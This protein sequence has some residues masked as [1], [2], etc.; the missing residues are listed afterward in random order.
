MKKPA[1]KKGS[2]SEPIEKR[3]DWWIFAGHAQMHVWVNGGPIHAP[4]ERVLQLLIQPWNGDD[5]SWCVYRHKSG[6]RKS[7]KIVFKKW[8]CE[9]DKK[10]FRAL[11]KKPMPKRWLDTTTVAEKQYAVSG[12]WVRALELKIETIS[13]PPIA[14]PVKPLLRATEYKLALWRCRQEANFSWNPTPPV[15][16][17]PIAKLFSSL[18]RAFRRFAAH[19]CEALALLVRRVADF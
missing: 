6:A 4:H 7:G 14:G 9:T 17:R 13:I 11:G 10:R 16:W 5:E 19:P 8:D 2:K 12:Q 18:L 3:R 1:S 15:A